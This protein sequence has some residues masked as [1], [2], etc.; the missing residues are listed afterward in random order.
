MYTNIPFDTGLHVDY[1]VQTVDEPYPEDSDEE[2]E[3]NEIEPFLQDERGLTIKQYRQEMKERPNCSI[4]WRDCSNATKAKVSIGVAYD[5]SWKQCKKEIEFFRDKMHARLGTRKPKFDL[6]FDFIF[7]EGGP[8]YGI[9]KEEK[10]FDDYNQFLEFIIA[11]FT[12]SSC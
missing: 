1:A 9:F 5:S 2:E 8:V 10:I 7:G 4:K 3:V 11:F 6:I 12:G